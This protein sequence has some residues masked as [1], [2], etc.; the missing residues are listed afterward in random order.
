M[1]INENAGMQDIGQRLANKSRHE[2]PIWWAGGER[3]RMFEKTLNTA[4]QN[5]RC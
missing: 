2:V 4:G 1:H 3:A 5:E